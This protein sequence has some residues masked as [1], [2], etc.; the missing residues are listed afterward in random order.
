MVCPHGIFFQCVIVMFRVKILGSQ[1]N[2]FSA[3]QFLGNID[4]SPWNIFP[5]CNLMF[6]VQILRPSVIL[7]YAKPD[8]A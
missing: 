8:F 5:M 6:R 7:F 3:N 2:L 4:L 1:C